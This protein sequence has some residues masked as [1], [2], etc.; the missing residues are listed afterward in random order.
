MKKYIT[1]I[2]RIAVAVVII[3]LLLTGYACTFSPETSGWLCVAGYAFPA[4]LLAIVALLIFSVV[5]KQWVA[6]LMVVVGLVIA[7]QPVSLYC[8][9]HSSQEPPEDAIQVMSYNTHYMGKGDYIDN[10]EMRPDYSDSDNLV[11]NYLAE[12]GADIICMQEVILNDAL[13]KHL[14]TMLPEHSLDSIS[15][16][17]GAGVWILSRYPI[18]RKERIEYDSKGNVSGAFWLDVKGRELIVV[19]NHL[20]TMGFSVNDRSRFREMV[21]GNQ[22]RDTMKT[23][24]RT[25][26][27]KIVEASR[28]RAVQAEKVASFIRMHASTPMI[29]CGDFNDIPQSYTHHTI[30]EGMTDCYQ[31]TGFGPGFSL[32]Q[33]GMRVR[34]DNILCSRNITPYSCSI[35]NSIDC[36]DHQPIR[37]WISF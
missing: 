2:I 21:H 27:G 7:Y 22:E 24:S 9:V 14:E 36:S 18:K 33:Y 26:F 5:V 34:I 1:L 37:C 35:D 17:K 10:S 25:I 12:T 8:P 15:S 13:K 16:K 11:I 28:K 20:E 29:V 19:N 30:A 31:E 4:F 6:V 23:T 3:G 32:S